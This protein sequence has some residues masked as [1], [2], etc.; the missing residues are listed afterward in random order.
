MLDAVVEERG[1]RDEATSPFCQL[2]LASLRAL[3]QTFFAIRFNTQCC[4]HI[5][6]TREIRLKDGLPCTSHINK[7]LVYIVESVMEA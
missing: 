4:H 5:C 3:S 7:Y 1:G 6:T 2:T